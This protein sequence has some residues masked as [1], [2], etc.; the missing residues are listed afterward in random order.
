MVWASAL[1]FGELSH[2]PKKHGISYE[3]D[4][5]KYKTGNDC[6]KVSETLV[7]TC[8]DDFTHV[9]SDKKYYDACEKITY[10]PSSYK[11]PKL[12]REVNGECIIEDCKLVCPEG[13]QYGK[14]KVCFSSTFSPVVEICPV[15]YVLVQGGKKGDYCKKVTNV[16]QM[17]CPADSF[18]VGGLCYITERILPNTCPDGFILTDDGEYCYREIERPCSKKDIDSHHRR[19]QHHDGGLKYKP[20]YLDKDEKLAEKY[21]KEAEKAVPHNE[22]EYKKS[23]L[24]EKKDEAIAKVG[25][26]VDYI[27]EKKN[28]Y[29]EKKGFGFTRLVE[30]PICKYEE[31][32]RSTANF[33]DVEVPKVP[34][35][36]DIVDTAAVGFECPP[37]F[38]LT[39]KKG[40]EPT[41]VK[42]DIAPPVC[43]TGKK[44]KGECCYEVIDK[45]EYCPV[46]TVPE[47]DYCVLREVEPVTYTWLLARQ[48]KG[49]DC[50]K[51]Y[52]GSCISK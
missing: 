30:T 4:L 22:K 50:E 5:K 48:C 21:D 11:C 42:T 10:I 35:H 38:E 3:I 2:S 14:E 18:E 37:D 45:E 6:E 20:V 46:G 8:P 23:Y 17:V 15:E 16:T 49:Y 40:K 24:I 47:A 43:P 13:F 32:I 12:T 41:C 19:L 1:A 26:V 7:R 31:F 39:Y 51:Y 25:G 9:E 36:R 34:R 29:E 27:K 33:E 52:D 28:E 44:T